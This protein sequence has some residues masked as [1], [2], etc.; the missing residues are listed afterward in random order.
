MRRTGAFGEN[1]IAADYMLSSVSAHVEYLVSRERTRPGLVAA[2]ERVLEL[3]LAA[4]FNL[5]G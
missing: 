2:I 4:G 3:G 1:H 5:D